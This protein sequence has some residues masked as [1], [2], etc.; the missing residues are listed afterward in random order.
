[1]F[2]LRC[3]TPVLILIGLGTAAS[4]AEPF[5]FPEGKH[6]KG[7]LK[8]INGFAVLTVEGAPEDIGEQVAVLVGQPAKRLLEFPRELLAQMVTPTGAKA[9]WPVLAKQSN[10]LYQNFP[11]DHR[12]ELET[13]IKI[14]GFDRDTLIAA[15]TVFD[16]KALVMPL[17]HC[18]ALVVEKDRSQS[19][20]PIFGRNMDYSSLGYLHEYTLIIV[21]RPRGKHAFAAVGW[22]GMVGVVSGINDA[23]LAVA[24]LETT[25]APKEEGPGFSAEG[26]PFASIYR[27]I[28]EE[29]TTVA[30][31]EKLLREA[32]RT[33]TNNLTVCD[34]HGGA[35][36]EFSPSRVAVRRPEEGCT[37]C[38]NHFCAKELK[39]A[40]PKNM[41]TTL[42]RF[43]MLCKARGE[44]KKLGVAEVQKY[45]HAANQGK[46]TIQT[47]IFEPAALTLH[48]A[49]TDGK[50][51][52]SA[53]PLK[54]LD[55]TPLLK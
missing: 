3:F 14:T 31:A 11:P 2:C 41:A 49:I 25:G 10:Q 39:L 47:M 5:R 51:P 29:C 33:T 9:L 7:E 46:E 43:A 48:L 40:Q 55:L 32:K 20:Q 30:E 1:M 27:R 16:M 21:C 53:L 19:G 8:Y 34:R 44:E 18:S 17:F 12:R 50:S 35:V 54:K 36:F 23:G 4:A 26:T 37:V 13:A 45:L 28:L 38:T 15:N 52:A 24:A 42:D 22:P 6:G